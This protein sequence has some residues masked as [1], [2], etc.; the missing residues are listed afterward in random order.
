MLFG[1]TQSK[2]PA[3][4]AFGRLGGLVTSTAKAAAAR[5]NGLKGGRPPKQKTPRLTRARRG[6]K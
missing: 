5:R 3:A 4:V 6:A 2:H 1:M